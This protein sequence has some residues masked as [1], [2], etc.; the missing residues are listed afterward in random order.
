MAIT[1]NIEKLPVSE[2]DPLYR[3]LEITMQR[4][5]H[6]VPFRE[7]LNWDEHIDSVQLGDNDQLQQ[8]KKTA[9]K[10]DGALLFWVKLSKNT[11]FRH[12]IFH[13]NN[14]G[15]YLPFRFAEPFT[16]EMKGKKIWFGSSIRLLEELGWLE[17]TMEQSEDNDVIEYWKTLRELC[18]TSKERMSAFQLE[19]T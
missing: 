10:N 5:G 8:L 9:A 16:L 6:L 13:P 18:S 15:F 11:V 19:H 17:M 12:L 7:H 2:E 14:Q 4:L 3:E 1:A